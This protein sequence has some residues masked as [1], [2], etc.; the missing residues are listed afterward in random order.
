MQWTPNVSFSSRQPHY[1]PTPRQRTTLNPVLDTAS[2][3][4]GGERGRLVPQTSQQ[5]P[6]YLL[7]DWC[8]TSFSTQGPCV[9]ETPVGQGLSQRLLVGGTNRSLPF[10]RRVWAGP[11]QHPLSKGSSFTPDNGPLP[12]DRGPSSFAGNAN[13]TGSGTTR[14]ANTTPSGC[15][16]SLGR[17]PPSRPTLVYLSPPLGS[18]GERL[19]PEGCPSIEDPGSEQSGR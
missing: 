7:N 17:L 5:P 11:I 10:G 9:L 2:Q 18:E 1:T 6:N 19:E 3:E 15:P 4:T 14:S 16:V 13:P 8:G 12:H